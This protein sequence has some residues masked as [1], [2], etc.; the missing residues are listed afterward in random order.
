[1]QRS[2]SNTPRY[3]AMYSAV[4]G[5]RSS[6]ACGIDFTPS[7]TRR[8]AATSPA[9][10]PATDNRARLDRAAGE[11]RRG[12]SQCRAVIG[13]VLA[14]QGDHTP[15]SDPAALENTRI[16]TSVHCT[17]APRASVRLPRRRRAD[18][19]GG[20]SPRSRGYH[21]RAR[22]RDCASPSARTVRQIVIAADRS[23]SL[24]FQVRRIFPNIFYLRIVTSPP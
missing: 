21:H 3:R 2:Q 9:C 11:S 13:G 4:G 16:R 10:W 5:A 23:G 15:S 14:A 1:M 20:R 8:C 6:P 12:G 22:R 17:L 24:L 7:S 19:R 18:H